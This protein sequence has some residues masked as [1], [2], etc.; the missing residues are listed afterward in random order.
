[1]LLRDRNNLA[2]QQHSS[3]QAR[4][5]LTHFIQGAGGQHGQ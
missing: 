2:P 5:R 1:L 4:P 3:V